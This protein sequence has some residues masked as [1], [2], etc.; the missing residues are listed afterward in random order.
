MAAVVLAGVFALLPSLNAHAQSSGDG[1]ALSGTLKTL[2]QRGSIVIGYRESSVPFSYLSTLKEPIGYSIDLCK[3]LAADLGEAVH[4]ELKIEWVPV[5]SA[6]RV[7]AVES[8]RVDIECGSTTNNAERRKQVAFSPTIF[9]AGT[10]LMVKSGSPIKGFRDLTGK[11]VAVTAGTTNEKT[12]RDLSEKFKLN[13]QLVVSAD[14]AQSLGRLSSDEA[15]AFATDD[16]L[17]YGFIAQK[18]LKGKYMVVGD[19]LSYDPYGVLYR[20]NDPAMAKVVNDS[21]QR[22]AQDGEI[23]RQ[24]RRWFL[25]KL[26]L[27][28]SI[29]LPMSAQLE[30]IIEAMASRASE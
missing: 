15:D 2:R 10:K 1:V 11:R 3:G 30:S 18:E 24:Y 25:R 20:R 23:E 21:F 4:R 27:G 28:V 5:T 8:G 9:V 6:T 16:V 17:L 12:M 13:I 29:D 22:M 26:P 19:Y 7:E 14:H